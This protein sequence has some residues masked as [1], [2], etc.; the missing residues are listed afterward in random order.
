MK[1]TYRCLGCRGVAER[2]LIVRQ[3]GC[4]LPAGSCD[5]RTHRP[6]RECK[7]VRNSLMAEAVQMV[8]ANRDAI[9]FRQRV[10]GRANA[11]NQL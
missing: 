4:E 2:V 5:Q 6:D 11:I 1:K 7:S 8:K 10:E 9:L 3:V